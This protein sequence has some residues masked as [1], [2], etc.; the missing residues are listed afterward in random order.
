[1][2]EA[3]SAE[4]ISQASEPSRLLPVT[5]IIPVRLEARNLPR[6]LESLREVGEVLVID[7]QSTDETCAIAESFGA[8][9]VQFVITVAGRKNASGPWTPSP[10]PTTGFSYSTRTKS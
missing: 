5:V 1:V 10:S 2:I 4:V 9:V 7:S 3:K 8:N 6:C